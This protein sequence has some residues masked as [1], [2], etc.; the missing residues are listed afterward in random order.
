MSV[1]PFAV[2]QA[3]SFRQKQRLPYLED[4]TPDCTQTT[5]AEL[6]DET[7]FIILIVLLQ[8]K[9]QPNSRKTHLI[10]FQY[11]PLSSDE[12]TNVI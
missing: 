12:F 7:N 6:R 8:L 1:N 2:S 11:K 10:L 4:S 5:S 9:N 3:L